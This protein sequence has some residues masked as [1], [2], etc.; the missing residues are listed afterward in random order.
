MGEID[1]EYV[2]P[3][4]YDDMGTL[5]EEVVSALEIEDLPVL[6][7][8]ADEEEIQKGP[9]GAYLSKND[10]DYNCI[11]LDLLLNVLQ[12]PQQVRD[13]GG[14]ALLFVRKFKG[15]YSEG[16]LLDNLCYA[17]RLVKD[18]DENGFRFWSIIHLDVRY[19]ML[20]KDPI[21]WD[22]KL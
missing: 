20:R 11:G 5:S 19:T 18:V 1:N 17:I 2:L 7:R 9:I 3:D 13:G 22:C 21:L 14:D 6:I 10:L 15:F 8:V 4:G 12:Y 16:Q